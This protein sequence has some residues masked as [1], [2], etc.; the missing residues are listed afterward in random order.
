[1]LY[2]ILLQWLSDFTSIKTLGSTGTLSIT[3]TCDYNSLYIF[4]HCYLIDNS[5]LWGLFFSS[6]EIQGPVD[7]IN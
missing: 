1:M 4:I 3:F 7:N 6:I 5:P 2:I